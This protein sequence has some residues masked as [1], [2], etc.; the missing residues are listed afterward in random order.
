MPGP[1]SDT[2]VSKADRKGFSILSFTSD[3]F[4]S[5][6][7]SCEAKCLTLVMSHVVVLRLSTR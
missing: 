7:R 2:L 1:L 5:I 6:S 4:T 3:I